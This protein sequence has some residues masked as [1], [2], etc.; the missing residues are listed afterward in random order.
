V[1]VGAITAIINRDLAAL[2]LNENIRAVLSSF[3][4]KAKLFVIG[5][6]LRDIA[7]N[8][9]WTT[10]LVSRDIDLVFQADE[11][12]AVLSDWERT[13]FGG[14]TK[15]VGGT[16][17]DIWR[18]E[19]TWTF[20]QKYF[21]PSFENLLKSVSFTVDTI[22]FEIGGDLTGDKALRDI[23]AKTLALN[24]DLYL[25]KLGSLQAFRAAKMSRK[26]GYV[27]SEEAKASLRNHLRQDELRACIEREF[28]NKEFVDKWSLE[29]ATLLE[30]V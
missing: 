22:A 27:I 17:M 10:A 20:K 16:T 15:C 2:R 30:C 21:S 19:D 6:W 9:R 7:H 8:L 26:Y 13:A 5:G 11:V 4:P 29:V 25:D 23:E 28:E 24:C 18:L 12:P 1:D 14:Y 3:E